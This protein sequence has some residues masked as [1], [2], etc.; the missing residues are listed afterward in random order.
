MSDLSK[1]NEVR[2]SHGQK[3]GRCAFVGAV[4]SLLLLVNINIGIIDIFPDAIAYFILAR[5]FTYAADRAPFFAEAREGFIKLGWLNLMKL[6]ALF[7][8]AGARM[9]NAFGNDTSVIMSF[10]FSVGEAIILFGTV[11]NSFDALFRLG[12]RGSAQSL[13]APIGLL[14]GKRSPE[15][16]RLL[17]YVFL[18]SKCV[19]QALPDAFL[20]TR[21]TEDGAGIVTTSRGYPI[22]LV[23]VQILGTVI[24]IIWVVAIIKYAKRAYKEG[25]FLDS[26]N[27]LAA[28]D[29]E[30]RLEARSKIRSISTTLTLLTVASIF[31][32]EVRFD[33]V[34]SINLLPQFIF[35]IFAIIVAARLGKF[36]SAKKRNPLLISAS[37]FSALSFLSFSIETHF[38]YY[39]GY[40]DLVREGEAHGVYF[41]VE[42]AAVVELIAMIT[43]LIMLRGALSELV[44]RH[45]GIPPENPRYSRA[46][47]DYH[48]ALKRRVLFFLILGVLCATAKCV[49]V[50]SRGS[51]TLIITGQPQVSIFPA[52]EWMG[53]VVAATAILFIGYSL[54]LF[55]TVKEEVEMKYNEL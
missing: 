12:E 29:A 47:K 51:A 43:L 2:N 28:N 24:G 53:L 34:D 17:S 22:S 45:T 7:I 1:S 46:D 14:G 8:I 4:I 32:L 6:P 36:I 49:N 10:A 9:N 15:G 54:Y 20:L 11:K 41:F 31:S 3:Y 13:I 18:L 30:L 55:A 48:S 27:M 21:T 19:F 50:F 16:L 25:Q 39:Y 40:D 52:L 35:G 23:I 44:I 42:L 33:N 37:A 38:L 26:L 5:L